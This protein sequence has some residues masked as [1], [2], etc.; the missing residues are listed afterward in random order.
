MTAED[1]RAARIADLNDK[2][3]S[4]AG[5]AAG[6]IPGGCFLTAGVAGLGPA[7]Q[8]EILTRVREFSAFNAGNDPHREH[9]FGAITAPTGERVFWKID[10]FADGAMQYGTEYPDDPKRSFRALT[11]MLAAEY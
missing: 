4:Q 9:D 8:A 10:Y 3:R 1:T 6:R 7:S 5:A 11:I 2:F